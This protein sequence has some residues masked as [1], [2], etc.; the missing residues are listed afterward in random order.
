VYSHFNGVYKSQAKLWK[1]PSGASIAFSAIGSDDDLGSWQGSQLTR[2]LIDEAADKWTQKQVLFLL[3]RLRSAHSKI[4]AQLIMSCNPDKG[5][6]LKSWV[7]YCLDPDTGVPV[8]GTEN[9]IR[10]F[11]TLDNKVL[12]ADSPEECFDLHGKPRGMVYARG[13]TE[14][15]IDAYPKDQLSL[16]FMPKSFRFIPTGVFDNPYLLPP[17]NNSYLANLLSQPKVNQLKYLH[18]SW[19]AIESS[20]GYFKREWCEMLDHEP[21]NIIATVRGMDVAGSLPS[22]TYPNPDWTASV[23]MSK[24]KDG[25]YIIR[26]AERYRKLINGVL[27]NIISTDGRDKDLGI[28]TRVYLPEDA[29]VAAKAA[30]MFFVKTLVEEDVDARID[31]SGNTKSKLARMQPFLALAEAGFVKFVKGDWNDMLFDELESFV[32][33]NRNQKDDQWDATATAC[34]ALMREQIM[35]VFSVAPLHQMSPIPRI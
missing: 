5:S 12:W 24:T 20:S 1:F 9:R 2:A 33:G 7:D 4:H 16:L 25:F 17:R 22:D 29:G 8:E 23:M 27:E 18:G 15:Q 32:D 10:W 34:K 31:K 19:T 28:Q 30:T 3:S 6:F 14:E 21:D 11:V 26:H 35:P 13:F